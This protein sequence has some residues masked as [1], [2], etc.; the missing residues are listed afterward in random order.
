MAAKSKNI[1]IISTTRRKNGNSAT[2]AKEFERGARDAGHTVSQQ[3]C[4]LA[5]STLTELETKK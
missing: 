5:A 4:D 3:M 1:L 2:L